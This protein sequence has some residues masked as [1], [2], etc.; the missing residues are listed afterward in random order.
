MTFIYY[1]KCS[2]CL[3][4]K[5]AMDQAGVA[6]EPRDIKTDHPD[7]EEL[8]NW[9]KQSGLPL[10]KWFNTSGQIYKA[11][12]LKEKL[13]TMSEEEQLQLLASD[14]MLVKRPILVKDGNVALGKKDTLALAGITSYT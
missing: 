9:W 13:V 4:V 8:R 3:G 1:P 6:Y 5:K 7:Y 2:T 14:G 12:N 11:M 10:S